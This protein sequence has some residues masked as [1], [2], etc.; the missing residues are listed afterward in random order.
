MPFKTK[1]CFVAGLGWPR[2]EPS[3]VR[4]VR[5][6]GRPGSPSRHWLP[7][8]RLRTPRL[9]TS[10]SGA[11]TTSG[12]S[13][14][15]PSLKL[16]HAEM[17]QT[18]N[19]DRTY[20]LLRSW[21]TRIWLFLVKKYSLYFLFLQECTIL[22]PCFWCYYG[23]H[24]III[25]FYLNILCVSDFVLIFINY[26][27]EEANVVLDLVQWWRCEKWFFFYIFLL[28]IKC[29]NRIVVLRWDTFFSRLCHKDLV[30]II[31]CSAFKCP[32]Q[33]SPPPLFQLSFWRMKTNTMPYKS[34]NE[35]SPISIK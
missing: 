3:S 23:G 7:W 19:L 22:F 4:D 16:P 21:Q 14:P 8:L 24:F 27:L 15:A 20:L 26:N 30:I 13:H 18:F 31:W 12:L 9:V 1:R 33:L 35:M 2:F 6:W 28:S 25:L 11:Q 34:T 29:N 32:S 5:P 10:S 17:V